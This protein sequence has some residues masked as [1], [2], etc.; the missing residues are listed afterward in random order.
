MLRSPSRQ[1]QP[2]EDR[3]QRLI[4]HRLVRV[5][6]HQG[7]AP[8]HGALQQEVNKGLFHALVVYLSREGE[9]GAPYSSPTIHTVLPLYGTREC[10]TQTQTHLPLRIQA[11]TNNTAVL[12]V[13]IPTHET[14]T[15]I[16]HV[17]QFP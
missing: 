13:L 14:G 2:G 10:Q 4:L 1:S 5:K 9:Q 16:G 6:L 7:L 12:W 15:G 17:T 11:A 3:S 8:Y